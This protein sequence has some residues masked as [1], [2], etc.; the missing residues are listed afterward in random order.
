MDWNYVS[1]YFWGD[2]E[3]KEFSTR[4][5]QGRHKD[6]REEGCFSKNK[7]LLFSSELSYFLLF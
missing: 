3:K 4:R 1:G 2:E 7:D 6:H 5:H